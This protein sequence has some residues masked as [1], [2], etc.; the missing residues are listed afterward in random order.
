M[1]VGRKHLK[2]NGNRKR[3]V[4]FIFKYL[5]KKKAVNVFHSVFS[6]YFTSTMT[7]G[8]RSLILICHNVTS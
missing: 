4:Q 8:E 6:T 7:T 1:L 3:R 2:Q 5:I